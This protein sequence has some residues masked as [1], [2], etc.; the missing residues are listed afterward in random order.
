MMGGGGLP[1]L[2]SPI[3]GWPTHSG[4]ERCTMQRAQV[5]QLPEGVLKGRRFLVITRWH[6]GTESANTPFYPRHLDGGSVVG[7]PSTRNET[8][9]S[10]MHCTFARAELEFTAR[11][12]AGRAGIRPSGCGRRFSWPC[13]SGRLTQQPEHVDSSLLCCTRPG[14][15]E[16]GAAMGESRL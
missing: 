10:R 12:T 3:A 15:V 14:R 13:C 8:T 2:P 5:T 6:G 9:G 11:P 16:V 1:L 7:A 4:F